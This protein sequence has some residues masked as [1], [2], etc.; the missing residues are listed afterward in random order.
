MAQYPATPKWRRAI[1]QLTANLLGARIASKL[2]GLAP[3]EQAALALRQ[4]QVDARPATDVVF[5]IPLVRKKQVGDWSGVIKRLQQTI[6]SFGDPSSGTWRALICCQDKP[7]LNWGPAVQFVPFETS[8]EGND[9]WAKL[10]TLAHAL[11]EHCADINTPFFAMSFDADDILMPD[12]VSEIL[13][14]QPTYGNL[15]TEG[16]VRD[17]SASRTAIARPQSL[18]EPGQKAFWK[19]CGSCVALKVAT[20]PTN[21]NFLAAMTAH[22]H[23]MF[24][25]LARLAGRSLQPFPRPAVLYLLNHG[26]NFGARRGRVGFKTR[27][28]E[29]FALKDDPFD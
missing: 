24:P 25:Y 3:S 19:L 14:Y 7:D 13:E 11:P 22:E 26:E 23:R 21:L 27:F 17:V 20:D 6:E 9:K 15:V 28:V 2:P 12:F 5:L 29:R 4:Q 10:N 18:R 8:F 1:N 16:Y